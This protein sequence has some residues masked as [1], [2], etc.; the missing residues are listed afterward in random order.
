MRS[1]SVSGNIVD[2]KQQLIYSGELVIESG[3]IKSILNKG[4]GVAGKH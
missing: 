4:I 2:I 3:I 1:F